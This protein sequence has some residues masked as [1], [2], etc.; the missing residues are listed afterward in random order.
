MSSYEVLTVSDARGMKDFLE[1]PGRIYQDDPNWIAPLESEVRRTLDPGSN[2]YFAN[3]SLQLFVCYKDKKPVAREVIVINNKH[4]EKFRKKTAFFGFFESTSDDEATGRLFDAAGQ[5]CKSAGA[6]FIEGPFNPNH[7]SELGLQ[8]NYFDEPPIFFE[9][10]NKE[11]YPKLLEDCGFARQRLLHT[12]INEASTEYV[13]R[14]YGAVSPP[15]RSGGFSVRYFN[16][17]GMR[18]ELE[19]IREVYNDAFSDNWHFLPLN[20]EEYLFSAKFLFFVTYPRLIVIV[21]HKGAP[22]GVLQCV[23]NI[24][25]V[26]RP[27]KG[28]L[29]TFSLPRIFMERRHI[30]EIVIYAIGIKKA[31]QKTRVYKLLLDSMCRIALRYGVVSTTW[32]SE[33]NLAAVR[34]SKHLGLKPYK[35]FAIYEKPL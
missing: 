25:R 9:T 18:T 15:M 28:K 17:L 23:L 11:Y 4:W 13:L 8:I 5:Y 2:P 20:R 1:L 24:N 27:L 19:R 32:M 10:Y 16:I 33:D 30:R 29:T 6:E 3:A 26:L 22:V 31:Y 35:Y 34:A 7:Y 21:E 12:R 14:R